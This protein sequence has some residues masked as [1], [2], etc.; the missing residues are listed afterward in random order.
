VKNI[1]IF[2]KLFIPKL[3]YLK[4]IYGR[5]SGSFR[6]LM[7]SHPETILDSGD[8]F[9]KTNCTRQLELTAAGTAPV[10]HRIPF[11]I[12]F[13][14]NEHWNQNSAANIITIF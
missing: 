13:V 14:D 12:P 7:P 11:L 4:R 10:F 6:L 8:V 2:L 5:S 9:N 1:E 3:N